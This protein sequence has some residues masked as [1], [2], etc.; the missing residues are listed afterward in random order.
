PDRGWVSFMYS[1]PNLIPLPAA[2]VERMAAAL[3]PYAFDAIQGAWWG[4]T[5][6]RGGNAIV[7]R[8]ADRYI[9]ALAGEMP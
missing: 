5:I 8:S 3:E 6:P 9:R 1:Y 4:T 2:E 7:R